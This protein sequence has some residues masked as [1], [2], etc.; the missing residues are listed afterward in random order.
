MQVFDNMYNVVNMIPY[1]PL[2]LLG[3]AAAFVSV[4]GLLQGVVKVMLIFI[5]V[6]IFLKQWNEQSSQIKNA[7]DE[8]S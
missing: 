5:I 3:I 2:I 4:G 1:N 8:S 7:P 6:N